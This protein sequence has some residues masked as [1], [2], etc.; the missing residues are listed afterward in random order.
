[1]KNNV[2]VIVEGEIPKIYLFSEDNNDVKRG[3]DFEN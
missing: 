2:A 1:M 3:K